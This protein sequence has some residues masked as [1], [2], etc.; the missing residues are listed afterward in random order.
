MLSLSTVSL[1]FFCGCGAESSKAITDGTIDTSVEVD[2]DA[3]IIEHVPIDSAQPISQDVVIRAI[4]TDELSGI[5]TVA[6]V[7]KRTDVGEWSSGLLEASS[8]ED[9]TWVGAIP[10]ADVNGSNMVYYITAIDTSGNEGFSPV[11]GEANPYG[12]RVNPDG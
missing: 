11:D 5:D 2:E 7:Y 4:I 10:G 12:F 3:P 1:C 8:D 9:D 6:V